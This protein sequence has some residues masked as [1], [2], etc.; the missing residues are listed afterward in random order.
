MSG[1]HPGP[2]TAL[3][4]RPLQMEGP[5]DGHRWPPELRLLLATEAES[6]LGAAVITIGGELQTWS[7]HQVIHKPLRSTVVQ[8]RVAVLWRGD[9][10]TTETLVAATGDAIPPGGAVFED[11]TTRVAVWR[12]LYDPSLPGLASALDRDRV[13]DLFEGLGVG[14]APVHLRVRAYRPGRRAVVEATGPHSRLYLKVVRPRTVHALHDTHRSLSGCLPVPDSL[15]WTDDGILV[16]PGLEG[17]TLRELLRSGQGHGIVPPPS[18]LEALLNRLPDTLADIPPRRDLLACAEHRGHVITAVLPALQGRIE[19]LLGALQARTPVLHEVQAVHGDLYEAQLL[20]ADGRFSGLLDVDTAGAGYRIDD[21]ANMCAHLSVL[22]L[23]TARPAAIKGFGAA[24]L[25]RA[26]SRFDRQDMR[27]RIA[28]A[29]LGLATGPFRVLEAD[30][31][32]AT[33]RRLELAEAW[34][35]GREEP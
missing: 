34:L 1:V 17:R 20:V 14:G 32:E 26:E 28:A 21:L 23:A 8:Y 33:V 35:G 4:P 12:W 3:L 30:W 24:L 9:R 29:V 16:L 2:V 27:A 6:I 19:D 7:A 22:A 25:A 15:G 13:G 5:R 18:A 10:T 11:G 31:P